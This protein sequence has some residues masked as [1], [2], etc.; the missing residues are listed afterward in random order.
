MSKFTDALYELVQV[1][2]ESFVHGDYDY[3]VQTNHEDIDST[4]LVAFINDASVDIY[5][6]AKPDPDNP[7]IHPPTLFEINVFVGDNTVGF[8]NSIYMKSNNQ[9]DAIQIASKEDVIEFKVDNEVR[10]V[11]GT[12][13]T[14]EEKFQVSTIYDTEYYDLLC[15]VHDL[16]RTSKYNMNCIIH[17]Y[18]NIA[19]TDDFI[20]DMIEF[21]GKMSGG[22][23]VDA[24]N[25]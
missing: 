4:K 6:Y 9:F 3:K 2:L 22:E 7:I 10:Y 14:E 1:G 20:D 23:R 12:I 15:C 8:T 21:S 18:N 19:L 11:C 13:M 25:Y 17:V 24:S 16:F 5:G